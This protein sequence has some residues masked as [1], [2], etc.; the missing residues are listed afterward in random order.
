M[1]I[2]V[3]DTTT[4]NPYKSGGSGTVK[5]AHEVPMPDEY[6]DWKQAYEWLTEFVNKGVVTVTDNPAGDLSASDFDNR[7]VIDNST[8]PPEIY[9]DDSDPNNAYQIGGTGGI[10]HIEELDQSNPKDGKILVQDTS[11]NDLTLSEGKYQN[12][13]IEGSTINNSTID[14]STVTDTD[15]NTGTV[16]PNGDVNPNRLF[17][18]TP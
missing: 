11:N 5:G 14:S 15:V 1:A 7:V 4:S 3:P 8:N 2:E 10:T 16:K 17:L 12:A 6:T 9:I 13:T 18:P